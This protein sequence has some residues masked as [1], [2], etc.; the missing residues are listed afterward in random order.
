[1]ACLLHHESFNYNKCNYSFPW[2]SIWTFVIIIG[3]Y[4]QI[5]NWFDAYKEFAN[6]AEANLK[7]IKRH[8]MCFGPIV[9]VIRELFL[10]IGCQN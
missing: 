8:R 5:F 9:Q 1:M 2:E 7:I 6:H 3:T 10:H 4:N